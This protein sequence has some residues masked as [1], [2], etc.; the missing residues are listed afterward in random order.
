MEP[1]N[2]NSVSEATPENGVPSNVWRGTPRVWERCVLCE[3]KKEC[4]AAGVARGSK[5]CTD[6]RYSMMRRNGR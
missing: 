4:S 2:E 5:A 1:E 3:L 6:A